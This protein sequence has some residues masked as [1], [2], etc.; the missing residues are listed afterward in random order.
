MRRCCSA[1]PVAGSCSLPCMQ[2]SW[3]STLLRMRRGDGAS[4]NTLR[5]PG[6]RRRR[7]IRPAA[8]TFRLPRSA[9]GAAERPSTTAKEQSLEAPPRVMETW[10]GCICCDCTCRTTRRGWMPSWP[11][12][13]GCGRRGALL[14]DA[15]CA[16]QPA[17][18]SPTARLQRRLP[19]S[20][21]P[22]ASTR[23]RPRP[24]ASG[25][26]STPATRAP[27]NAARTLSLSWGADADGE[28]PRGA[29]STARERRHWLECSVV[30]YLARHHGASTAGDRCFRLCDLSLFP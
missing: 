25:W 21:G 5:P 17:S 3:P 11:D 20:R 12:T 6:R 29:L 24:C 26:R 23:R 28:L 19:G 4:R 30:T 13:T 14:S 18:L 15:A 22:S 1:G 16:P 10:H 9:K 27:G 8:W 2:R 7:P